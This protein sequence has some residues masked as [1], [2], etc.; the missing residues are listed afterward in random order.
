MK[1]KYAFLLSLQSMER[2]IR[3]LSGYS[4]LGQEEARYESLQSKLDQLCRFIVSGENEKL[5][6]EWHSHTEIRLHSNQLRETSVR[7]LCRIEKYQSKCVCEDKL[8]ISD[9]MTKLSRAVAEELAAFQINQ[10]SKVLFIGSGAF[11]LSALT[12]AKEAGAEVMCLDSDREA[13]E[14]GRKI[15]YHS[16]LYSRI[17]FSERL[18]GESP[19]LQEATHV[20][21]ASLVKD[22]LG[23]LD[24]IKNKGSNN[25]KVII[26][27]GNGLKSLFNYPLPA[28]L[29][30]DWSIIACEQK[31]S[32]YDTVVLERKRE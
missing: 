5:W 29:T 13:V 31:G 4:E 9:Y 1:D 14:M 21:I 15:S 2:E 19:Y 27:Y 26:R 25:G 12:I 24:A 22:K 18:A 28:N 17:D 16:G 7:A 3:R 32:I 11:P 30:A 8:D 6:E 23:V 20:I 10:H